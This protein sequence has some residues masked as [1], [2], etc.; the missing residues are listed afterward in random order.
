MGKAAQQGTAG[1]RERR[2]AARAKQVRLRPPTGESPASAAL[3]SRRDPPRRRNHPG[4]AR[5][6]TSQRSLL[7]GAGRLTPRGG[8]NPKAATVDLLL[9]GARTANQRSAP[10]T[11]PAGLWTRH[12][13]FLLF[14]EYTVQCS[15]SVSAAAQRNSHFVTELDLHQDA[16]GSQ[17]FCLHYLPSCPLFQHQ[18]TKKRRGE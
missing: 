16:R 17:S 5:S 10:A 1:S 2:R 4:C 14:G 13:N 9:P 7:P 15:M 8:A 11:A 12:G 18:R 6:A 3:P